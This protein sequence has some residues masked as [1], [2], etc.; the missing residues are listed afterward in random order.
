MKSIPSSKICTEREQKTNII[1][2]GVKVEN[3]KNR[4]VVIRTIHREPGSDRFGVVNVLIKR[5]LRV[6]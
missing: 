2:N 3:N 5:D 4:E 6:H 1:D